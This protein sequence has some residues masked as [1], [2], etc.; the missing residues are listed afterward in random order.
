[1]D[2]T[3]YILPEP[4]VDEKEFQ[5]FNH[6]AKVYEKMLAPTM[7]SQAIS[8]ASEIVPDTIKDTLNTAKSAITDTDLF[9]QS[10]AVLGKSFQILE[11]FAAKVTL[12]EKDV[13]SKINRVTPANNISTLDEICLARAYDI[14]SLVN[15]NNLVDIVATLVE[16]A[17]T[18]YLGFAGLPFNLVLSTFLYYRAVQSVALFY[19]YDIKNDPDELAFA[20]EVFISSV[21]PRNNADSE[22]SSVM[23]KV[24]LLTTTTSV[25]QT[26][27]KGWVAMAEKGGIHLLITQMRAL[28]HNAAKKALEKAGK[29]GLEQSLFKEVFEQLGKKLTQKAISK[30]VPSFGAF[31][32]AAIDSAQ[33]IQ[34]LK[35]ANVFYCKRFIIEKEMRINALLGIPT[36]SNIPDIISSKIEMN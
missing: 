21:S 32:G 17:A 36:S 13:V 23:A 29:K 20:S 1:M 33:M 8:K 30:A 12:S 11:Q 27:K 16:G 34:I 4:V 14:S 22:V 28:A 26:V 35:Y 5:T 31:T 15:K 2:T 3:T 6:L 25:Q 7:A 24:M 10:M 19:G 9:L 18:G